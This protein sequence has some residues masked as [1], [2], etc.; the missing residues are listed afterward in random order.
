MQSGKKYG[1]C[2]MEDAVKE[3]IEAGSINEN[4][5]NLD[6]LEMQVMIE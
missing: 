1:M 2:T 5:L 4:W 3:L 6:L